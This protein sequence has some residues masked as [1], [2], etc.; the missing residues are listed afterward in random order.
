VLILG[1]V[2]FGFFVGWV[3]QLIVGGGRR[4]DWAQSLVAGLVGSFV[5]GLVISLLAG[6]GLRL[7]PSGILGSIGGAVVVL[8]IWNAVRRSSHQKQNAAALKTRRS[9]KHH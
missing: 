1:L 5:G 2:V 4:V 7:R 9:G 6:D 3:A 8:L